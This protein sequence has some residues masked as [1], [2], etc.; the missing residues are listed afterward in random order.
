MFIYGQREPVIYDLSKINDFPIM[1]VCGEDDMLA[2]PNDVKW[3]YEQIKNNVIYFNIFPNM[4]HASFL[5]GKDILWFNSIL[6]IIETKFKFCDEGKN[7]Y[8]G[9]NKPEHKP[10]YG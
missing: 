8:K 5:I 1:L 7:F 6:D 9:I 4:G 2:T 3:L 10:F